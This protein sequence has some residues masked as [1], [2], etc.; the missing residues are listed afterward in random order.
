MENIELVILDCDRRYF[1]TANK[2]LAKAYK[3]AEDNYLKTVYS[4][5]IFP[6]LKKKSGK[7]KIKIVAAD[8]ETEALLKK[9]GIPFSSPRD[10]ISEKEFLEQEKKIFIFHPGGAEDSSRTGCSIQRAGALEI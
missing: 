9:Q 6:S 10:Y 5:F 8:K 4:F 2:I 7:K 1:P 3:F